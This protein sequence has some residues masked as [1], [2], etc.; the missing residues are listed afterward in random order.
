MVASD[1]Q[2]ARIGTHGKGVPVGLGSLL[3]VGCTGPVLHAPLAKGRRGSGAHAGP[4]A[5]L[6]TRAGLPFAG[7]GLGCG[8]S[9]HHII[10]GMLVPRKD[11]RQIE[12]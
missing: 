10:S 2:K 6:G 12:E 4:R 8:P 3:T 9:G 7:P 5:W 1:R 11:K